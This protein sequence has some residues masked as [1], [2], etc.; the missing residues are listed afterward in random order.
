MITYG[1]KTQ[2]QT[3]LNKNIHLTNKLHVQSNLNLKIICKDYTVTL[4]MLLQALF[5]SS[6]AI[7]LT[8]IP[9]TTTIKL[10]PFMY[11]PKPFNNTHL[12]TY[13]SHSH[14]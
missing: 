3:V 4:F 5:F 9:Y 1:V 11:S 13:M 14:L 6:F 7:H 10:K 8:V 12:N 2:Y